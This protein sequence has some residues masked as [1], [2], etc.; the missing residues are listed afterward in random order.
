MVRLLELLAAAAGVVTTF[1]LLW[2][3]F[4][5]A[6]FPVDAELN[7]RP[8]DTEPVPE[9]YRRTQCTFRM[10]SAA[11]G[12]VVVEEISAPGCLIEVPKR[13]SDG[14]AY[15]GGFRK[16]ARP[17][18]PFRPETGAIEEFPF[19]LRPV[20]W[21]HDGEIKLIKIKIAICFIGAKTLRR[22]FEIPS[23]VT[24]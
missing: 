12:H 17:N 3:R 14:W 24:V 2:D 18:A 22:T 20:E 23:L 1:L 13:V 8:F 10:R 9:G 6:P 15:E 16:I 5:S 21:T 11:L 7:T 4:L 19:L